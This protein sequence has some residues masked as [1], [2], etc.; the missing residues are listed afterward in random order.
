MTL[1]EPR[2]KIKTRQFDRKILSI[3][4]KFESGLAI[5]DIDL[6]GFDG[7]G[8]KADIAWSLKQMSIWGLVRR[9]EGDFR[10]WQ[11]TAFGRGYWKEFE[12]EEVK[13]KARKRAALGFE[14]I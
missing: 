4:W 10:K 11:L 8:N 9:S 12:D 6:K 7:F 14:E 5:W 2:R 13:V 3:L 1:K